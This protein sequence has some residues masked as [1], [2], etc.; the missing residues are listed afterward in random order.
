M[1]ALLSLWIFRMEPSNNE[2]KKRAAQVFSLGVLGE[3]IG[4]FTGLTHILSKSSV[5]IM[6]LAVLALSLASDHLRKFLSAAPLRFTGGLS[7]CLY[8]AHPIV[9]ALIYR[10]LHGSS[11]QIKI[12]RSCLILLASY[13]VAMLSSKF[14][15]RPILKLKRYFDAPMRARH[16]SESEVVLGPLVEQEVA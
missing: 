8:L 16:R 13:G 12:I 7:Y 5:A 1:G 11:L 10:Q 15:E 4:H 6:F 3:V 14:L 9:G 2:I